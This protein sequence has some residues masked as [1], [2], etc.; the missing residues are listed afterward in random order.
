MPDHAVTQ[1]I[2]QYL[3]GEDVVMEYA[4]KLVGKQGG[5]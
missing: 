5:Y 3:A 1:D 4:L 2:G